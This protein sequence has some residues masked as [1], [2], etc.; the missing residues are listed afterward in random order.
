MQR[1]QNSTLYRLAH[2]PLWIATFFLLHGP[3]VVRLLARG[4]SREDAIWL[5]IV[6]LASGVTGVFGRLPGMEAKPYIVSLDEERVNPLY[7][8]VCFTAAWSAILSYGVI[9]LAGILNVLWTGVWRL[10]RLYY[11]GYFA[12]A[13]VIWILGLAGSLPRTRLSTGGERRERRVFLEFVGAACIIQPAIGAISQ[14]LPQQR[15]TYVI[16]LGV[17][18]VVGSGT[19]LRNRI[20]KLF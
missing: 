13:A 3:L 1:P 20:R 15:R 4:F 16:E 12:I 19:I 6:V 14:A 9:N 10:Q 7:R 11:S 17:F 2:W 5:G 18:L 8:R